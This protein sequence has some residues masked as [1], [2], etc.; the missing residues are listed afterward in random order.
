MSFE[1]LTYSNVKYKMQHNCNEWD[2]S[3]KEDFVG[4]LLHIPQTPQWLNCE[5]CLGPCQVQANSA[6]S[7]YILLRSKKSIWIPVKYIHS[8]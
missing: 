1:S 8:L 6:Q 7:H 5:Y 2:N 3:L 4:E